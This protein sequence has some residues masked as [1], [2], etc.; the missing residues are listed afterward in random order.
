MKDSPNDPLDDLTKAVDRDVE[1]WDPDVEP[2]IAGRV[3]EVGDITTHYGTSPTVNVLTADGRESRSRFGT[4]LQRILSL[5]IQP[6]D[7]LAIRYLGKTAPRS[8]QPRRTATSGT[9]SA[10]RTARR[11]AGAD[12]EPDVTDDARS[13]SHPSRTS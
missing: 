1:V 6:G 3:T 13:T 4:V 2:K 7:L 5:P 9:S 11:R 8:G 10:T 12:V